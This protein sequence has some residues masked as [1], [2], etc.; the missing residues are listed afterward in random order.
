MKW[1]RAKIYERVETGRDATN[2]PVYELQA[3]DKTILVRTAPQVSKRDNTEGNRFDLVNRT[4]L[5]KAQMSLL[6]GAAAIEV[7]GVLY[8]LESVSS[9]EAPV[10]LKVKRTLKQGE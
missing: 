2:N 10:A 4:F 5:T 7:A 1:Y 3:T 8:S 9:W 6:D